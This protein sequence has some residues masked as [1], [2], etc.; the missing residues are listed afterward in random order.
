MPKKQ[1]TLL[2]L[3]FFSVFFSGV[4]SISYV[5]WISSIFGRFAITSI[6]EYCHLTIFFITLT[7]TYCLVYCSFLGESPSLFIVW[8][9]ANSGKRGLNKNELSH[10]I[11]DDIFIKPRFEYLIEE[12][13]VY[14]N[15]AKYLLTI[16]GRRFIRIICFVHKIMGLHEKAS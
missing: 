1:M 15:E 3:I 16:K 8:N 10:L 6:S 2:L 12:K 4:L 14:K 13:M 11:T 7:F 5:Q 9:I